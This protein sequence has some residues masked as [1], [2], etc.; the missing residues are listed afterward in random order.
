[1]A[2]AGRVVDI[3]PAL[4]VKVGHYR[5]IHQRRPGDFFDGEA[6]RE[7][8]GAVVEM[9]LRREG[10]GCGKQRNG[11]ESG[12]MG[13]HMWGSI[14]PRTKRPAPEW[15]GS[16]AECR[17]T[18]Y[19]RPQYSGGGLG[20]G[21]IRSTSPV[22]APSLTLPRSARGGKVRG[23]PTQL[24]DRC[25]FQQRIP[26]ASRAAL[27]PALLIRVPRNQRN[28]DCRLAVDHLLVHRVDLAPAR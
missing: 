21:L 11:Q 25:C 22:K 1:F 27:P 8:E 24:R 10:Q 9:H 19:P 4:L 3:Q 28:R 2:G 23:R 16:F 26:L 7:G 14:P 13:P 20:R 12:E 5:T 15:R 18:N 17:L 6:V